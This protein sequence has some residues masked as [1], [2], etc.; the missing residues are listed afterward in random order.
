MGFARTMSKSS[1]TSTVQDLGIDSDIYPRLRNA[2]SVTPRQSSASFLSHFN[3][4]KVDNE[5]TY[6]YGIHSNLSQASFDYQLEKM[7]TRSTIDSN[8]S[9]RSQYLIKLTLSKS[10]ID[11]L[12]YTWNVMLLNENIEE[13]TN[14]TSSR[15]P[16]TFA[17]SLLAN[18]SNGHSHHSNAKYALNSMAS[19]LFCRQFYDN[20]LSMEPKLI[21][22]FPSLHH[23]AVSFAGVLS[24]AISQLENL[25]SLE[26]FLCVLGKKHSRIL[27]I[28]AD[29]FELMGEAL[30]KTF[31]ERF[32]V[33][34]TRELESLWIKL[35][36]YLADSILQFGI[37]PV[38]RLDYQGEEYNNH[39]TM[40]T[41]AT[42]A[43]N[44]FYNIEGQEGEGERVSA[45][46]AAP[47]DSDSIANVSLMERNSVLTS[48]TSFIGEPLQN[49]KRENRVSSS[50]PEPV[51]KN[52]KSKLRSNGVGRKFH[53]RSDC[54]IM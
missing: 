9:T 19:S 24:F 37:D 45:V 40:N 21:K 42:T 7:S 5:T 33:R 2:S 53:K 51:T 13:E 16:G 34:F 27:G 46:P 12:R 25:S 39:M 6:T 36:C 52:L 44:L 41:P 1:Y 50:P 35:Y 10:D 29:S 48:A 14:N 49:A 17:N 32:G 28:S 22:M 23:Q 43:T 47:S 4:K 54:I 15:I 3:K 18:A 30:V 31:H 20:L 8:L 38:M 11:L 26:D